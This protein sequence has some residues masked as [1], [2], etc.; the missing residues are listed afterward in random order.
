MPKP[1]QYNSDSLVY[2]QG[3]ESDKVFTLE[4]GKVSLI[5]EDIETRENAKET[6][7]PGEFFGVRSALGRYP[8]DENAIVLS[9]ATVAAFTVPEFELY[10]MS[11]TKIILNLLK[12]F[13]G[14]MRQI[15]TRIAVM[16]EPVKLTPDEGL[17]RIGEKY[18]KNE[19]H[20]HAKYIFTRYLAL[21]PNGK[22]ADKA[23]KNLHL[24]EDALDQAA[25]RGEGTSEKFNSAKAYY[26]AI[27]LIKTEKYNDA[28]RIFTQVADLGDTNWAAKGVYEIGRC[29]FLLNRFEECIKHYQNMFLLNPKHQDIKDAMFYVG[30]S[31]ERTGKKDTATDWYKKILAMPGS[32]N[33]KIR[34]KTIQALEAIG[35]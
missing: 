34:A 16:A 23:A 22:N 1:L 17:F 8:R 4:S 7:L 14:E 27:N 10:A 35:G 29:L 28:M 25:Q 30:Q 32:D 2:C 18:L 12:V 31:C 26:N 11:D 6:V 5:S 19:R 33:D 9:E 24:A 3:D 13:S 20:S 21:Y 15:H